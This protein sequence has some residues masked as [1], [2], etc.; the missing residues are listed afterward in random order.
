MKSSNSCQLRRTALVAALALIL[1][2]LA[3]A[4]TQLL[5]DTNFE[6]STS[7]W[8]RTADANVIAAG[9][10]YYNSTT[11]ECPHDP[12]SETVNILNGGTAV[13]N[14][15]GLF[16]A[17]PNYT[18]W[19]QTYSAT[20]GSTYSASGW[21]YASHE[22]L[23]GPN[24]FYFEVDFYNGSGTLLATYESYEA[25]NLTCSETT[26]FAVDTWNY[27]AVTNEMQVTT[28][29]NTGT[30]IGNTGASGI[31]TAPADTATV[32]Y[33]A[34]FVNIN[35]AGGSIYFDDVALWQLSGPVPPAISTV[36]PNGIILCTNTDLQCTASSTTGTIANVA[37][38]LTTSIINGTPT[39][40][41]TNL[42]PPDVIGLDTPSATVNYPLTPN[43]VYSVT[44][45]ATDN[46]GNATASPAVTFDTVSPALVIEAE[47][48]NY[49]GGQF[50]DTPTNGGFDLYYNLVGTQGIDENKGDP[51]NEGGT[52]ITGYR[53][54]DAVVIQNA[55]P[56]NGTEQKYVTAD[57]N[58]T[59]EAWDVPSEVGYNSP[60][61]WLDYTRTYGLGGSAPAGLYNVWAR[62]ATDGSG[63]ASDLSLISG[64]PTTSSQTTTPL[65]SFTFTDGNWNT[66]DYVP[67]LDNYGNPVAVTLSG[68]QTLRNTV[69]G[70]PNIG[71]YMLTPAP[72]VLTPV[73][74][75]VYP[76]GLHPF[77]IT[78]TFSF[79][80][81]PAQGAN[82]VASGIHLIMN[83]VD[84]TSKGNFN[85]SSSGGSWTGTLPILADQPSY[86]A[87]IDVTN[88]AGLSS[89][90][91]I[92]FDTFDV[93]NYIWEAV[94]YDF[95]TNGTTGG[96]F[97]DNPVPTCDRTAAPAGSPYEGAGEQETNSYYAYPTGNPNAVA[98]QGVDINFE[99]GHNWYRA[100]GVG[101]EVNGDYVRPKF[102]AAQKEFNDPNITVVD[103][104]WYD[105][106]N[107]M[108]YTRHYPAGT[109][110]V[111]GRL[112]G[113]AGPFSGT[114]LDLVTNGVGTPN[115]DLE[116]LGTFADP[117]AA[118]WGTW[119]WIP[120]LG[121]NGSP[122][123]VTLTGQ[124][125][126][127]RLTSGNNLNV[128]F[129][130]LAPIPQNT[131]PTL[132]S[133]SPNV[134]GA[135]NTNFPSTFT[136][137][138]GPG[139][140]SSLTAQGITVFLN[141]VNVTASPNF[142]LTPS[143]SN[144]IGS[145]TGLQANTVYNAVI[146]GYNSVGLAAALTVNF[147]TFVF[148]NDNYQLEFVDYDFS[149]NGTTGGL[150]IDNPVP[151][152]DTNALLSGEE[153]TNSYF[154]Y[155][156][157]NPNAVALQAVDVN[158]TDPGNIWYRNDGVGSQPALDYV[159][160]KFLASQQQFL[161]PNIGP[162]NIGWYNTGN[163]LNYT[164]HYPTNTYNVWGRLAG[165]G[166]AFTGT[167]LSLVTSGVGTSDQI[168][169]VLGS[170]SDPNAA[171]WQ[172]WHW[173]PLEDAAGALVNV[174][175]GGLATL[176]LTSGNNLNA[177]F[178]MLV[179]VATPT[180]FKV[181]ASVVSGQINLAFPTVSGH[182]YTV[183]SSSSLTV[184]IATWNV[185][186]SPVSGT[187]DVVNF[188]TPFTGAQGYYVVKM[189]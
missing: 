149:T 135:F 125:T 157:A 153:A 137:T 165:G 60:G 11:G 102:V 176:R 101:S 108:N 88:T 146:Q 177:E 16:T 77:E 20:P 48:F 18:T 103:L 189:Q 84:V 112:A 184:P 36:T 129:L 23:S 21:A 154:N 182:S 50:I 152:C 97:I 118:G 83:G 113:G 9:A 140:D 124:A 33:Q 32:K 106:G 166:G 94:D 143:G 35:F 175:L 10:T 109:Y 51:G 92:S 180:Q 12:T 56:N 117:N 126:T 122:V 5:V 76:D 25:I 64:D 41:T 52:G 131:A 78:N 156:T 43:L 39:T 65:G 15:Y 79:T 120:L 115:Q 34:T 138:I 57:A 171:G 178:L 187:G 42:G 142:T 148:N 147:D 104:G 139:A 59:A 53:P 82:I 17:N 136:F 26:P 99:A 27:L 163:W 98:L 81:G 168:T 121:A 69:V 110:N 61:D 174:P 172:T 132:V 107:W 54:G 49:S 85:L 22:D 19:S 2:N 188:A 179:P 100:D 185:V 37:L 1:P 62:M 14:S 181:T 93:N 63:L 91:T 6:G 72:T 73:L 47:D 30:I 90:F 75:Y 130:M 164:R 3:Q 141:G 144:W 170:F 89:S 158:W 150:F 159:R 67:L 24:G 183:L 44:V 167:T 28:G 161:D 133:A 70:N 151:S 116:Q 46:D 186:G 169:T 162:I 105:G 45:T 38:T 127:M 160:P 58:G 8:T 134:L 29:T 145:Y 95:S 74:Q 96:L 86:T 173:V 7:A 55:A 68:V 155:P 31:F 80:V 87:V 111:Y 128:E 114:T 13:A 123:A 119:H 66:F 4:Q 40:V 71:F